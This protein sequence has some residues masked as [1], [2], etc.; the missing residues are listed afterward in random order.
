MPTSIA[1]ASPV[2]VGDYIVAE[3]HL[4][5]GL[6]LR[7][8]A[9]SERLNLAIV[10]TDQGR[11]D[12]AIA[13]L[14]ETVAQYPQFTEAYVRLGRLCRTAN[15]SDGMLAAAT[16]GLRQNPIDPILHLLASEAYFDRGELKEGWQAY[17]WRFK[18][19][20]NQVVGKTYPLPVWQGEDLSDRRILAWT[21][22]APGDEILYANMLPDLVAQAKLCAIQ[23]SPRL[24]PLLRRSFPAAQ[25]FD[26]DLTTEE[27]S[28]FDI[29]T[30]VTSAGEWLRSDFASFPKHTGYLVADQAQR[31]LLR[32]KYETPGQNN[33]VV[34]L[35][36]RSSGVEN[37]ADKTISLLDWGPILRVPGVTFVNLQYGDC[38]QELSTAA[39]G[40][41]ARVIHDPDINPLKDMDGFAAQ[42][43]VGWIWSFPPATQ[44]CARGGSAGR[45]FRVLHV[46]S[47]VR[48]RSPVVVV[49]HATHVSLVSVAASAFSAPERTVAR[50]AA[51]WWACPARF[52][53]G[54]RRR[55]VRPALSAFHGQASPNFGWNDHAEYVYRRLGQEPGLAAEALSATAKLRKTAGAHE[56]ALRLY[57]QAIAA[58]PSFW[59]AY[60]S[61]G[62]IL[63]NQMR[64]EEAIAVYNTAL[65]HAPQSA[66]LHNNL[67]NALRLSARRWRE[68]LDAFPGGPSAQNPEHTPQFTSTWPRLSMNWGGLKTRLTPLARSSTARPNT[69]MPITTA[70]RPCCPPAG[71]SR[72]GPNSHGD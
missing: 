3:R 25:I 70:P 46:T 54:A 68:R 11:N 57:D 30:S 9:F 44:R 39:T 71:W 58:D 61:K 48:D 24:A 5:R 34:G 13:W 20:E 63:A 22:Q 72:D 26:R 45:C 33:C 53:R 23:C 31:A 64:F 49:S 10:L 56:E 14:R 50:R 4:R 69:W 40:F 2:N 8:A 55:L 21:E 67:G 42:V 60:N 51:R 32:S 1:R 52:C 7:P 28:A 65:I 47:V 17:R 43:A 36:W 18:S 59:H 35:A 6:Q 16:A 41:G 12:D 66:E 38:A 37:A 62:M 15:D 19:T 29:Q 27:I